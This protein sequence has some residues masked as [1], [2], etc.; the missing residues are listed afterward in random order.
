MADDKVTLSAQ[1]S[2]FDPRIKT[3]EFVTEKGIALWRL[4]A[5][6]LIE[7]KHPAQRPFNF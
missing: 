5:F 4:P 6:N 3:G 7:R 1:A 2:Q